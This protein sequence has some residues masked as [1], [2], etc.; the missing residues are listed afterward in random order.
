[1]SFNGILVFSRFSRVQ[2]LSLEILHCK[3]SQELRS[4][5]RGCRETSCK[6]SGINKTTNDG[7]REKKVWEFTTPLPEAVPET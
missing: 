4:E 5:D 7:R 3:K 1:M 6:G 2:Y